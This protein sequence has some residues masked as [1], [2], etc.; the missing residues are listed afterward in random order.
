LKTI[1]LTGVG[2]VLISIGVIT[3][4]RK[5]GIHGITGRAGT[6]HRFMADHCCLKFLD[7]LLSCRFCHFSLGYSYSSDVHDIPH[8]C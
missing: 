6:E 8:F 1:A 5:T 3:A 7:G 4:R 2:A